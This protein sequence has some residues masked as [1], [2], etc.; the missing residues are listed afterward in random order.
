L[1][2]QYIDLRDRAESAFYPITSCA[3]LSRLIATHAASF[4]T[5]FSEALTGV[6]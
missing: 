2:N 6:G 4:A 3:P 1:V 5:A